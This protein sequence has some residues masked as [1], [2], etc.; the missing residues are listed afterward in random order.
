MP[1]RYRR[2]DGRPFLGCTRYPACRGARGYISN[3]RRTQPLR[4]ALAAR[5]DG[6]ASSLD[7][8]GSRNST[9]PGAL[10]A[11]VLVAAVV[12]WCG[13]GNQT[14]TSNQGRSGTSVP[15]STFAAPPAT[16]APAQGAMARCRD[17]SLSYSA[18][19]SGTCSHQGGMAQWY[20]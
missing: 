20:Q 6:A 16:A 18:T 10:V 2:A 8:A 14:A 13:F 11:L 12:G 1:V 5:K 17:G 7:A 3:N 9:W 15:V 4:A 19:H